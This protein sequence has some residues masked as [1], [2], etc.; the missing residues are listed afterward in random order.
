MR[1]AE[2]FPGSYPGIGGVE[3]IVRFLSKILTRRGHEVHIFSLHAAQEQKHE[4]IRDEGHTHS[5]TGCS[6][7]RGLWVNLNLIRA[8]RQFDIVYVYTNY[9]LFDLCSLQ[10]ILALRAL[11]LPFVVN[12]VAIGDFFHHPN[13][14][15]CLLGSVSHGTTLLAIKHS[16]A[17]IHVE[18]TRDRETLVR[19][20]FD[21]EKIRLIPLGVPD[22][23]LNP[24]DGSDFR[25]KYGLTD[26]K[27]ILFV[28]RLHYLKGPHVLLRSA[29]EVIKHIPNA[30]FVFVGPDGGMKKKLLSMAKSLNIEEHIVFTDYVSESTKFEAYAASEVFVLPSLYD[31]VEAYSLVTS[32][33]W[34][35]EKPVIASSVGVMPYRIKHGVNGLL[36]PPRNPEKLAEAIIEVVENPEMA[37]RLGENGKKGIHT[38]YEFTRKMEECF[39]EARAFVRRK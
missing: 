19:L 30:V 2:V 26:K 23:A 8:F 29:P 31:H 22:Y 5:L 1:I 9:S 35:Q 10:S 37:R 28:G 11:H 24:V 33:A 17:I 12:L 6:T 14:F 4:I 32:E 34:T 27:I 7:L 25:L 21:E 39:E 13:F 16:D 18:N 20:G 3:N 38:W 15:K 36:V